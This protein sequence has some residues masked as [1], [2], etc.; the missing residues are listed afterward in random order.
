LWAEDLQGRKQRLDY[1]VGNREVTGKREER[2]T[3]EGITEGRF[4]RL[5]RYVLKGELV[6][7]FPGLAEFRTLIERSARKKTFTQKSSGKGRRITWM[8]GRGNL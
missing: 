7:L 4:R 6:H 8:F 5:G 3:K 1:G 2:S